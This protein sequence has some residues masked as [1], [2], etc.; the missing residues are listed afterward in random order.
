MA[1]PLDWM[2]MLHTHRT[3]KTERKQRCGIAIFGVNADLKLQEE[4][5]LKG[6]IRLPSTFSCGFWET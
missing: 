1:V 3:E 2:I 4:A 5:S 6:C